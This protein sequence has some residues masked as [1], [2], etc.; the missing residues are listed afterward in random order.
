MEIDFFLSG[1]TIETFWLQ[2]LNQYKLF[3]KIMVWLVVCSADTHLIK[4]ILNAYLK[5]ERVNI[6]INTILNFKITG[7]SAI[8]K[9]VCAITHPL[10]IGIGITYLL[11]KLHELAFPPRWVPWLH[12]LLNRSLV[13]EYICWCLWPKVSCVYPLKAIVIMSSAS[14]D[15]NV[16]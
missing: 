3:Q 12:L 13:F 1:K 7:F 9:L 11:S 5:T 6:C 8:Q 15:A 4:N 14:K 2:I 10:S 16:C